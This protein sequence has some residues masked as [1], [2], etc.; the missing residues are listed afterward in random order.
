MAPFQSIEQD[1]FHLHFAFF[2]SFQDLKALLNCPCLPDAIVSI[3]YEN[4]SPR[5]VYIIKQLNIPTRQGVSFKY[6]SLFTLLRL[7]CPTVLYIVRKF[8]NLACFRIKR[9]SSTHSIKSSDYFFFIS[10]KVKILGFA[11]Y[12]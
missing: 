3:K 1:N 11:I 8:R 9:H 6:A 10:I 12:I 2:Y 5:F 4:E 7:Y